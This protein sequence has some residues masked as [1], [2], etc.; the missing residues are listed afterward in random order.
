MAVALDTV[1][2]SSSGQTTFSGSNGAT[3]THTP[4]GAP[5]AVL[6]A[7]TAGASQAS[8]NGTCTYNGVSMTHLGL[9]NVDAID[10]TDNAGYLELFGLA[11][12]PSGA[13]TVLFT[14]GPPALVSILGV[15]LGYTGTG[16]TA[17]TA[18]GTPGTSGGNG[19]SGAVSVTGVSSSNRVFAA[20]GSGT[21]NTSFSPG[22]QRYFNNINSFTGCGNGM[23]GDTASSAG[24][25][26]V[27]G[28]WSGD[29]WAAIA[30]ELLAG[31]ATPSRLPQLLKVR[32]PNGGLGAATRSGSFSR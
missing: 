24:T 19:S 16:T 15:S 25:V 8:S 13:Q 32:R 29:F 6:V 10:G 26:T 20:F 18:F 9:V 30:V 23:G 17:G 3:W 21:S 14:G 5:T 4:S 1:S 12:P 28:L 7:M 2:P 31:G 22:T 11:N 27:T